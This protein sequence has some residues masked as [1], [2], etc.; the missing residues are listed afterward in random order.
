MIELLCTLTWAVGGILLSRPVYGAMRASSADRNLRAYA[1]L[2]DRNF[3][4][5][6]E[7]VDF[8]W[9]KWNRNDRPVV[10][11]RTLLTCICWPLLALYPPVRLIGNWA[12]GSKIRPAFETRVERNAMIKRIKEL[13]KELGFNDAE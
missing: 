9:Q 13:E 6:G 8:N 2:Y 5:E 7:P 11:V 3:S 1:P 12:S 4:R 10:V